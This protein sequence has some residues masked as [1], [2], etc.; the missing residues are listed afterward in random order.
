MSI[1]SILMKRDGMTESEA[2]DLISEAKDML[3]QYIMEGDLSSA[4]DVCADYF[5]L[6]PDY[7]FDLLD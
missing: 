6:E 2:D 3:Q 1:K 7:I 4:E 5:G